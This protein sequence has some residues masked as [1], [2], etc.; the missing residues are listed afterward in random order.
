[1]ISKKAELTKGL[2]FG[3]Q[4]VE[5]FDYFLHK[6]RSFSTPLLT[7]GLALSGLPIYPKLH[8]KGREVKIIGTSCWW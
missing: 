3:Q 4:L 6:T 7:D 8:Q 1:M 5:Q 2:S